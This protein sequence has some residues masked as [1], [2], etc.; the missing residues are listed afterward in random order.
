MNALRVALDLTTVNKGDLIV[1]NVNV[2]D[3]DEPSKER[4]R[5]TSDF[6]AAEHLHGGYAEAKRMLSESVLAEARAIVADRPDIHASFVSVDG[7][8]TKEIIRYAQ[9]VGADTIVLGTRS[10][11]RLAEALFVGVSKGVKNSA[12]QLVLIVPT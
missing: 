6:A 9:E 10:R 8:P 4:N 1:L 12:Q 3:F 2:Y 11:G 7:D 5:G